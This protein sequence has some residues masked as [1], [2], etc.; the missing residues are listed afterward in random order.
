M[1]NY[2]RSRGRQIAI[3]ALLVALA[4]WRVY[5]EQREFGDIHRNSPPASG[6]SDRDAQAA[7]RLGGLPPGV[8]VV[9]RV[10]DGDTLMLDWPR[11]GEVRV[12]LQ[13]V[14]TPETVKED[15]PVEQWGPEASQFTR[16]FVRDA[17]GR[18]RVEV[19]GEPRD[20]YDRYLA[21]LWDGERMLNEEL[22]RAGLAKAKLGYDYSQAKKDR[23]RRA[24]LPA[25]R[26]QRGLWS[27]AN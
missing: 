9:D 1:A 12:R 7:P 11:H 14:N 6:P 24:Q 26:A 27:S 8:Y 15:T 19:D 4:L 18:L 13:G 2:Q 20:Q 23:L 10:I 3:L 22:V 16:D 25:Q 21:F 5:S 17:G